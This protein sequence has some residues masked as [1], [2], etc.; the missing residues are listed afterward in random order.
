VGVIGSAY[1][2][3]DAGSASVSLTVDG[4]PVT[5]AA[6][7]LTA[8]ADYTLLVW[9][10]ANGNQVTLISDDNHVRTSSSKA[11]LRLLN[12]LSGLGNAVNLTANFS[13]VAEGTAV[14]QA[15]NAAQVDG[16]S[17]YELDVTDATNGTTLL[18]QTG[19][20]LTS[21]SVYT[22]FM[23]GGASSVVGALHKHR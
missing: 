1:G 5:A 21:G 7:T 20:T 19:I 6:Q 4:N 8:G 9:S 15:S 18:S 22:L 12:G 2:Q 17:D 14:G 10:N 23:A 16:A 13:P 3:V 11:K